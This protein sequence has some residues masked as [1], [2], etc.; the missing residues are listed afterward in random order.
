[1]SAVLPIGYVTLLEAGELLLPAL[2]A[3]ELDLPIVTRLRQEGLDVGDR[4]AKDEAIA[5]LWKAVDSGAVKVLAVGDRRRRVVKLDPALTRVPALP[6]LRGRSFTF[7]RPSTSAFHKL[8]A[9]FGRDLS[10]V[11]VVFLEEEIRRLGRKLKRAR[12]KVLRSE[13][14]KPRGRPPRLEVVIPIIREIIEERKVSLLDGVKSLTL[15]VNRR[16]KLEPPVSDDTIARAL[17]R[18]YQETKDR[19]FQRV[20]KQRNPSQ[21]QHRTLGAPSSARANRRIRQE[22]TIRHKTTAL[23]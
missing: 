5:E 13:G 1:M 3:G 16:G 2:Y 22:G 17:D 12:R 21:P 14:Q 6:N 15:L 7:L 9:Y 4:A 19:R 18:L 23:R 11:T 8:A 20:C 10:N